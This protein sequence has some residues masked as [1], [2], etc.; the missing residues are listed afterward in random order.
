MGLLANDRRPP[1]A[2]RT[3]P[4]RRRISELAHGFVGNEMD[5]LGGDE[6]MR[7]LSGKRT[8]GETMS[9]RKFEE[10]YRAD[11]YWE[12]RTK[13]FAVNGKWRVKEDELCLTYEELLFGQETC[14]PVYRSADGA[15]FEFIYPYTFDV[16]E[17]SIAG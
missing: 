17:F 1:L 4:Y 2:A 5:R 11:G 14:Y 13:V 7:L 12:K 3:P 16:S 10:D 8:T 6:I 9:G 15:K